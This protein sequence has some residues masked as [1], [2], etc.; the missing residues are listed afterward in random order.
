MDYIANLGEPTYVSKR[1]LLHF[2]KSQT[3]FCLKNLLFLPHLPA[4]KTHGKEPLID[5]NRSHIVTSDEY[6]QILHKKVM[7][8]EATKIFKE[9]YDTCKMFQNL[10]LGTSSFP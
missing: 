3:P 10:P 8:R 7:D 9:H 5:N 6:L 2:A 4:K 1:Q